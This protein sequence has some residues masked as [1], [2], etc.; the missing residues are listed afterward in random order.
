MIGGV[1]GG[2]AGISL[3]GSMTRAVNGPLSTGL[4]TLPSALIITL[5][6]MAWRRATKISPDK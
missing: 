4:S 5:I 2:S 6:N 1:G 3:S